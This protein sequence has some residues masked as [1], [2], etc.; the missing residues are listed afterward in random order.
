MSDF[1]NIYPKIEYDINKNNRP[2]L[3]TNVMVR[4]RVREIV[5]KYAGLLFNYIVRDGEKPFMVADKYY[6]RPE[7]AELILLTNT[8]LDPYFDWPMSDN[9]LNDYLIH[10]Y[11]SFETSTQ[12]V[13]SYWQIIQPRTE[14][15]DGTIVEERRLRV[16]LTTYLSLAAE[17]RAIKY[18]YDYEVELNESKRSISLIKKSH[19]G[20]VEKELKKIFE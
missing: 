7:L 5:N 14:Y 10:K 19:I 1:F 17:E 2:I 20:Q 15:Y 4:Y 9:E 11:G 3:A 18:A 8:M 13:H 6:G 16:D 12:Q